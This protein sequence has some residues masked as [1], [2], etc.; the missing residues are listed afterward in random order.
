MGE[1]TQDDRKTPYGQQVR[2]NLLRRFRRN[3]RAN[4]P[5][6][7]AR[8]PAAGDTVVVARS[9]SSDVARRMLWRQFTSSLRM[10]WA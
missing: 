6:N 9:I 7:R 10:A 8:G 5:G 2:S 3:D 4:G 1:Q